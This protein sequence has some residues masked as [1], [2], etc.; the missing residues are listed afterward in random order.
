MIQKSVFKNCLNCKKQD[1]TI[2]FGFSI[3]ITANPDDNWEIGLAGPDLTLR[4]KRFSA[5]LYGVVKRNGQWHGS[6]LD[7]QPQ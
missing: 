2:D 6:L 1:K 3:G 7:F 4:P 5:T